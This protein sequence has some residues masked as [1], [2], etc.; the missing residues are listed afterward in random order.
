MSFAITANFALSYAKFK[1]YPRTQAKRYYLHENRQ[2]YNTT[3]K[4]EL[5]FVDLFSPIWIFAKKS[6]KN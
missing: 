2:C 4:M 5:S 6:T 3:G 1:T